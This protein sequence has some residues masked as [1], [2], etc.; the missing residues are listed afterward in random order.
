MTYHTHTMIIDRCAQTSETSE[1]ETDCGVILLKQHI[2]AASSCEAASHPMCPTSPCLHSSAH[3]T[4]S[5]QPAP[6]EIWGKLSARS[7]RL[8]P[9]GQLSAAGLIQGTTQS[10]AI[11]RSAL[12]VFTEVLT[13]CLQ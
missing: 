11:W 5:R 9:C 13:I 8:V 7:F 12:T 4:A 1:R 6:R 2:S 10:F 3:S